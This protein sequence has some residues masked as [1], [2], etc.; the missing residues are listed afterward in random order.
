DAADGVP[1][2][3]QPGELYQ[4]TVTGWDR[5]K[6]HRTGAGERV[7]L[8]ITE[9]A[10]CEA[11]FVDP[12][13][14]TNFWGW[15]SEIT[16]TLDGN[17]RA[18]AWVW[19]EGPGVCTLSATGGSDGE[20]LEGSPKVLRW[21]GALVNRDV[22]NT[23]FTVSQAPVPADGQSTGTVTVQL[24]DAENQPVF[25]A[26]G[27]LSAAGP[28]GGGVTVGAFTHAGG[29]VYTATFT[30]TQLGWRPITVTAGGQPLTAKDGGGDSAYF[31]APAA[32]EVPSSAQSSAWITSSGGAAA[33]RGNPALADRPE[34]WDYVTVAVILLDESGEAIT[35]PNPPLSV[36]HAAADPFGGE[37]LD[38]SDQG[39][40][41]CRDTL[42][43]DGQCPDGVFTL[44]VYSV[45][46]GIRRLQVVYGAGT[47]NQ[48]TLVNDD[49]PPST[50]LYA[51]YYA[52]LSEADSTV[53]VSPSE[54]PD[55]PDAK[56]PAL[57]T[58]TPRAVGEAYTITVTLWDAGRNNRVGGVSLDL[59]LDGEN[60]GAVFAS[61]APYALL[62]ADSNGRAVIRATSL[63]PGVCELDAGAIGG[64]P[65]T[66]V[67][68]DG[69][70]DPDSP[71]TWFSVSPGAV[72][73][74]GQDEGQIE[75]QLYGVNGRPV[76]EAVSLIQA[77]PAEG[78]GITVGAFAHLGGGRYTAAFTGTVVGS[79]AI[80]LK[81]GDVPISVQPGVLGNNLAHVVAADG[82]PPAA[83]RSDAKVTN[84]P[85]ELANHGTTGSTVAE[86]GRQTITAT[87]KGEDGEP[88]TNAA[89][90]LVAEAGYGDPVDGIGLYFGNQ[91]VFAC[92]AAPVD[93]E[94]E[95][96]V[97]TLDV[98]S[99]K[100]GERQLT[101][102]YL[103]GTP[104]AVAL[105]NGDHKASKVLRTIFATPPISRVD[106]TVVV[107]PS[108]PQDNPDDPF[109]EPDGVPVPLELG[110]GQVYKVTV[111]AWDA[112]RNNR[113]AGQEIS[114]ALR[115]VPDS[116][117]CD[118]RFPGY[119]NYT[120]AVTSEIGQVELY[121]HQL[122]PAVGTCRLDV[123]LM[124]GDHGAL[125]GSPKRLS[126]VNTQVDREV[127]EFWV[128]PDDVAANGVDVGDIVV[129]L[130]GSQDGDSW[131]TGRQDLLKTSVKNGAGLHVTDFIEEVPGSYLA[132][133][134]GTQTGVFELSVEY[135]GQP[136]RASVST[137]G[138]PLQNL[139][140]LV[141]ATDP[142][143]APAQSM[144]WGGSYGTIQAVQK[145]AAGQ[146]TVNFPGQPF[147]VYA[148]L[149]DAAGTPLLHNAAGLR[150]EVAESDPFGDVGLYDLEGG[151]FTPTFYCGATP[152]SDCYRIGIYSALPGE[153]HINVF[154]KDQ[155]LEFALVNKDDPPSTTL[156]LTYAP[157]TANGADSTMVVSPSAPVDNPLD[158]SDPPDGVPQPIRAG[159][160]YQVVLTPWDQ[161]RL[162]R[163]V[164]EDLTVELAP[165]D[166]C[167][168]VLKKAGDPLDDPSEW[169][170]NRLY[171][172]DL[173]ANQSGQRVTYVYSEGPAV[174][175]LMAGDYWDELAGSPK[176]L[177]WVGSTADPEGENTWF[178]VSPQGVLADGLATGTVTVQLRG[179]GDVPVHDAAGYL[180]ASG[181]QAGGITLGAF[182]HAGG[183]VYTATFTGTV[184]GDQ[185]ISVSVD[186]KALAVRDPGNDS[187]HMV[188]SVG[189]GGPSPQE[190]SVG[191]YA[192][193]TP[194]ANRGNPA[195]AQRPEEWGSYR[196]TAALVD[197]EGDPVTDPNPPLSVTAA[198]GDPSGG[199][200]LDYSNGGV[201]TCAQALDGDGQCAGGRF[202]VDVYSVKAG[203][204]QLEVVY[205]AGTAEEFKLLSDPS[206]PSTVLR[207]LFEVFVSEEDSTVAITPSDPQDDPDAA[208][209]ATGTPLPVAVGEPYTVTVTLWDAG[210]NNLITAENWVEL[211]LEGED[212]RAFFPNNEDYLDLSVRGGRASTQVISQVIGE[213]ELVS[214]V[215][216]PSRT[217]IWGDGAVDTASDKTWFD[218]SP[219]PVVVGGQDQGGIEVQLYGVNGAPMVQAAGR[220]T[221]SPL[222]QD[223]GLT[224]SAFTHLG[225]G[226]YTAA[227]SGAKA[228]SFQIAVTLGDVPLSVQAGIGND[229]ARLVQAGGPP[230][231]AAQS[232]A[233]ITNNP[234]QAANRGAP[235]S[236]VAEWGRQT[237]TVTL[238]DADGAPL[239]AA[240]GDL[241]AAAGP[242]DPLDGIGLYFG[243]QNLFVCAQAPEAG[244]CAAGVY[245]LDVYSSK[246][247]ERQLTVT[248]LPGTPQAIVLVNGDLDTSRVLRTVFTTP[249]MSLADS[250]VVVTPSTPQDN[251]DDPLDEPDGVPTPVGLGQANPFR[252]T[253]TTWDAG[254]NNRVGGQRVMLSLDYY[255]A[256]GTCLAG[257]VG[258]PGRQFSVET[259]A[260]GR[261]EAYV[262]LPTTSE[263]NACYLTA[264]AQDGL[265][266]DNGQLGGSP[267]LLRWLE[268]EVNWDPDHTFFWVDQN[269]VAADGADV[270]MVHVELTGGSNGF[271]V[272]GGK[273][274]KLALEAPDGSGIRS[275]G[276]VQTYPG[277]YEGYFAGTTAGDYELS[278]TYDG[279]ALSP[280]DQD[281]AAATAHFVAPSE[282]PPVPLHSL[283]WT[284]QTSARVSQEPAP[285]ERTEFLQSEPYLV[286]VQLA[287][288][289]AAS[290][291]RN[292]GGLTWKA[293]DT[294]PFQGEG[295]FDLQGG[296]FEAGLPCPGAGPGPG[297]SCYAIEIHSAIPGERHITVSYGD[298]RVE[299]FLL[300]DKNNIP[301]TTLK[302]TY[303]LPWASLEDSTLVVSPSAPVDNPLDPAD[304]ADG[305]ATPVPAGDFYDVVLT[306]WDRDRVN[307]AEFDEVDLEVQGPDCAAV[308]QD[309]AFPDDPSRWT[310]DS[311]GADELTANADGQL[312]TR[313][314]S[315]RPGV[316]GL[317]AGD[318]STDLAGS[319]KVLRWV[320][321]VAD[322]TH[323]NTWF[324]VSPEDV[325]ADGVDAGVVTVQLRDAAGLPVHDAAEFVTAAG[326]VGSGVAVGAFTHVGGG[327]Y[328]A[329]FTGAQIG[330]F[331]LTA[332]VDGSA[333]TLWASGQG[334]AHLVAAGEPGG[335]SPSKSSAA[336]TAE[337]AEANRGDPD[338]AEEPELWGFQTI[339]VALK[340]SAGE[341]VT[342]AA[343]PLSVAAA[344][345]DPL[346]G[347]GLDYS[348][349]GA[350][351]CAEALV[352]GECPAGVFKVDVYS[353]KVGV[354]QLEV[355]Y[356]AGTPDAFTLV[357]EANAPSTV[358]A[359][360]FVATEPSPEYSTLTV[361][362]SVP[363][364]DPD[365]P[366]DEPDGVP[367][368]LSVGES[369]TVTITLWDAGRN[370]RVPYDDVFMVDLVGTDG[371]C[372]ARFPDGHGG[373]VDAYDKDQNG[374]IVLQVTSRE[375]GDCRIVSSVTPDRD[376]YLVW[377]AAPVDPASARTWFSVSAGPVVADG[378]DE[379]QIEVQLYGTDGLPV[380]AAAG[381]I[382]V[383]VPAGSGVSADGFTDQGGGRYTTAFTGTVPGLYALTV[384]A[385][386]KALSTHAG[387]GN[388]KAYLV[389]PGEPPPAGSGSKA[390]VSDRENQLANHDRPNSTAAEWGRQTI[391]AT[392]KGADG[393]PLTQGVLGL[394]AAAAPGDPVD[395]I[396]L[397][398]GN[399]GK[400]ACATALVDGECAAGVYTLDVYSSKAGERQLVVTYLAGTPDQVTLV[401]GDHP[402]S[403]VL[404]ARFDAPPASRADSI[405]E[406]EPIGPDGLPAALINGAGQAY[407]VTVIAWDEGRNNL[408]P[409]AEFELELEELRN[410][411]R[412][413]PC[414][415]TRFW[416]EDG[417]ET[418][419]VTS[420]TGRAETYVYQTPGA[421]PGKC[422]LTAMFMSPTGYGDGP[423]ADS[424]RVLTWES[425]P[426]D[427]RWSSFSV[428]TEPVLADG[429]DLG[430]IAVYLNSNDMDGWVF[431]QADRL[432]VKVPPG[433]GIEVR[434]FVEWDQG[435]YLARFTGT[436]EGLW[437]LEVTYDGHPVA[438]EEDY[439]T[440]RLYD[441][442]NMV[443]AGAAAVPSAA[444]SEA[445]VDDTG[446]L[447][448]MARPT[449]DVAGWGH[450]MFGWNDTY[451]H[452]VM[453]HLVD[454]EGHPVPNAAGALSWAPAPDDPFGG[455]GLADSRGGV[456]E[457]GG[458]D[459][460]VN[461][462]AEGYYWV[463]IGSALAGERL[464][465]VS[466]GNGSISFE[467]ANRDNPPSTELS[468]EFDVP[469]IS[470]S[471]STLV[472][473][474]SAPQ[475]NPDD[476]QDEP[477][478]V[479]T[480]INAGQSYQVTVTG[481]S[482]N[483]EY[484]SGRL[485]RYSEV[486]AIFEL[487]RSDSCDAYMVDPDDPSYHSSGVELPLDA[488]GRVTTTVYSD[489]PGVCQLR[490]QIYGAGDVGGS[491]KTLRWV[492][493][494]A[495]LSH[496]NTW[497]TVSE[498]D[499]VANGADA[500]TVTV[501]LRDADNEPVTDAAG[502]L[503]ASAAVGSGVAVGGFT[504]LGGGVYT[505][506]FTGTV[507]GTH[508]I[509]ATADGQDLALW[510]SG[511]GDA[512][513]VAPAAPGEADS[514]QSWAAITDEYEAEANRGDPELADQPEW[515]GFQT[516][517]VT[518]KDA[519]GAPIT[520]AAP[521]LSVAAAASD[522]FAGAGLDYSN[523][524]AFVCAEALAGGECAAGVYTL[525]V[526]SVKAG[527]RQLEVTYSAGGPDTFKL[528]NAAKPPSP[529][530]PATFA[531]WG[532][533]DEYSTMVVSP[534][535]PVDDPDDPA[536]DDDGVPDPIFAGQWYTVT[537]TFWDQ[538]RNNRVPY[539]PATE[540]RVTDYGEAECH[541]ILPNG[542]QG[543]IFLADGTG[544]AVTKFYSD[545]PGQCLLESNFRSVVLTWVE[546]PVDVASP[547]TWFTVSP[548]AVLADGQ[549]E[550][551][552]E[553]QL[554]GVDG[555]AITG[556]ASQLEVSRPDNSG[557]AVSGFTHT[558]AGRYTATFTGTAEGVFPLAVTA[559]G[560]A[561]AV[562]AVIGNDKAYLVSADGPPPAG[563]RSF[564]VVT[565]RPDEPANHDA[566]SSTQ[567]EWGRQTITATLKNA[568][569]QAI[570]QGALGLKAAAGTGDPLDGIGLYYGNGGNFACAAAPVGG[571]C[572]AGV[573][574]LD[575]YSSKA[576]ER[577]LTVTYRPGTADEL[578]LVNGGRGVS[579][580]LRA[581]FATPPFSPEYSTLMI[582]PSVP[583]DNP[584]DPLDNPD[585][586]PTTLPYGR[587]GRYHLTV[588]TWDEGRNNRV[589]GVPL[590]LIVWGPDCEAKFDSHVYEIYL[591]TSAIGRAETDVY[592][593]NPT[594]GEC[595]LEA[596]VRNEAG[597]PASAVG[598]QIGGSPKTLTW[599][600]PEADPD[601][602]SFRVPP[603]EVVANGTD[604][605]EI[606]VTLNGGPAD[607]SVEVPGQA[608]R[609]SAKAPDGS[610]ITIGNFVED[611]YGYVAWFTGTKA[612]TY[613]IEVTYDGQPLPALN[614]NNVVLDKAV[615]VSVASPR[616]AVAQSFTWVNGPWRVAATNP[617]VPGRLF[618]GDYQQVM[619]RLV[620]ADG[621]GVKYAQGGLS[622][623]AAASD[624]LG[625]EGLFDLS[626]G[627]FGCANTGIFGETCERGYYQIALYS[628]KPGDR[629]IT[630]SYKDETIEFDVV[631]RDDQP[632]TVLTVP[633]GLPDLSQLDSTMVVSPSVPVDDPNDPLDE[634]DGV[635]VPLKVGETY[636]VTVTA[637]AEGRA[638][639]A[640][641]AH[642]VWLE[643]VDTGTCDAGFGDPSLPEEEQDWTSLGWNWQDDDIS[644]GVAYIRGNGAG[645][646]ILR[647][648][649][650]PLGGSPKTLRWVG[651][652]T[653]AGQA[654][655]WYTVSAEPVQANG[656][657]TGTITVQL[658]DADNAP[659]LDAAGF[660]D[661]SAPV[662]S[663]VTV[664]GFTHAGGGVYT[665]PYTGVYAG[666]YPVAVSVD[667]EE[668]PLMDGGRSTTNLVDTPAPALDLSRSSLE[669]LTDGD[670]QV[671]G[672]GYSPEFAFR[673]TLRDQNG[674]P[675]TEPETVVFS[676]KEEGASVW[677]VGQSVP[678]SAG[679][680][681]WGSFAV[682]VPGSY[683]VKAEVAGAQVGSALAVEF[684]AAA[685]DP[686]ESVFECVSCDGPVLVG[687]SHT[688]RLSLRDQFGGPW[689]QVWRQGRSLEYSYRLVGESGWTPGH[690]GGAYLDVAEW[691]AFTVAAHGSYEVRVELD[692]VQLGQTVVVVFEPAPRAP[693]V[694][695]SWLVQPAADDRAAANGVST[696]VVG[697]VVRDAAGEPFEGAVVSFLIPEWTSAGLSQG[698][699]VVEAV[700]DG[701]G[702]ASVELVSPFM[703]VLWDPLKVS[704]TVDGAAFERL[705][706]AGD[707]DVGA[708][709]GLPAVVALNF[710]PRRVASG[711]GL[712]ELVSPEDPAPADGVSQLTIK[713]LLTDQDG[714]PFAAGDGFV[715]FASVGE[716]MELGGPGA[717]SVDVPVGAS[718]VA[719]LAVASPA[720]GVFEFTASA[721]ATVYGA[722][723]YSYSSQCDIAQ[724][725]PAVAEFQNEPA[726]LDVSRSSFEWLTEGGVPVVG[727]PHGFGVSLVDQY[728]EAWT[729]PEQVVFSYRASSGTAWTVGA[730]LTTVNGAAEWGSFTVSAPGSYE[731]KAEVAGSQVGSAVTVEFAAPGL[732]L[733]AIRAS[734]THSTGSVDP[735]GAVHW[736]YVTVT[737][738]L[739]GFVGG[740]NVSFELT[741]P[742]SAFLIDRHSGSP[743]TSPA[744]IPSSGL[745]S[746]V[747]DVQATEDT[748][749]H[750]VVSIGSEV[751]GEVDFSFVTPTQPPVL[752]LSQSSFDWLTQG[753][754]PVVGSP[755]RF[756]VSLSD[757]YGDPWA[758][759][760]WIVFSYRADGATPWTLG[761]TVL[762][763]VDGTAEWGSFAVASPGFY[764]V[765]AEYGWVGGAVIGQPVTVEFGV[766]G[767]DLD[768]VRAS[769]AHSAGSV[770][771]AG[772][773]HW[774]SVVVSDVL[775]G[776]VEGRDVSVVLSGA[777][778]AFLVDRVG[779]SVLANPAVIASSGLGAA[780][781]G[782][783]AT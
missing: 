423:I 122:T 288:A 522:P 593:R 511:Q 271:A 681:E 351:A 260:T 444:A 157:A 91:G 662:S 320:G 446:D 491:P 490:V 583:E 437:Q 132:H 725:S 60:C 467:L 138:G 345:S 602:S 25:D 746:A 439:Y 273:A 685:L 500:G 691:G 118:A 191:I 697:A 239:T 465:T 134:Y 768:A 411:D 329:P 400:F 702:Y 574:T 350:F 112:G 93:G 496:V 243:N 225:G 145:P 425:A 135:D 328:T 29:G 78:S 663:G 290:L 628:S 21:L 212:C 87:L 277:R 535:T 190:S 742:G 701:S 10:E 229:L 683:E 587:D 657:D 144:F 606:R 751:V 218:V 687:S 401:N 601:R 732:D 705:R 377:E 22:A 9:S 548:G 434:D 495:D 59:G 483:R 37:G 675:W 83:D 450:S 430:T 445:W 257:F 760:E 211:K 542:R 108:N 149:K 160:V 613:A 379:G 358:L 85:N 449:P 378:Q 497:Y 714:V 474:P 77:T 758:S 299:A 424:P 737:D 703:S 469:E 349:G 197:A 599:A 510:A 766:P 735:A 429:Q 194:E 527:V 729:S 552:I 580:V 753:E 641:L 600:Y 317:T 61:G 201:F 339:T 639:R 187:A 531:V 198:A 625:G 48:F 738:M 524:G 665:A 545:Q 384:T 114:L 781:V 18:T 294:D 499:V 674:E 241:V 367:T 417:N 265:T 153:R 394:A 45:K 721:N 356:G 616:P 672:E 164:F 319:P 501:Q 537:L 488:S 433:S 505:A 655:T 686:A 205:G 627:F 582:T 238:K 515:W 727:S 643:L 666:S 508:A 530:L 415:D 1:V 325:V 34:D 43:A 237:I 512:R 609:L 383:G 252:I 148:Q 357:N 331:A 432:A 36:T 710:D 526:Y 133:F 585:G 708:S 468:L 390:V 53:V 240:A 142:T 333:L 403:S 305:V 84:R 755:H 49:L 386:G 373:R 99:S 594:A 779:G 321:S 170:E 6:A 151:F 648:E 171:L 743:L 734:F 405:L 436:V 632:N 266:E 42:D 223:S 58:P 314:Y 184:V 392:L 407:K 88:L 222:D 20:E 460:S 182:R 694:A 121:V 608:A 95:N 630:I 503:A 227:F 769:F 626:D 661:G 242:G 327:V 567:A 642:G 676:Y 62:A 475:D 246:A 292:A 435:E 654:D 326:P 253:V 300:M 700:T 40:F 668:L 724:G 598:Q 14:P 684:V 322:P 723:G 33:N 72:V 8:E 538:G 324:A 338:L 354:R 502:L 586:V 69:A 217:L 771:P 189:G 745:G 498:Q 235:Q 765:K 688:L 388:D 762:T 579:K 461:S 372:A 620:D 451:T 307:R 485:E 220:L 419:L 92:A 343:P 213:C 79:H 534:S 519:A 660:I 318:Y 41:T 716:A 23:W 722:G 573:Y 592:V 739:G 167:D 736:A 635:P 113:V 438:A 207:A 308:F 477:D 71:K 82:P 612:G 402:A 152:E 447:S 254:R 282:P 382:V 532:E 656:V 692:G 638:Q 562:Q 730:T 146:S 89:A 110:N 770:D 262:Y 268:P 168:A 421:A 120:Y 591:D 233:V 204:R 650:D 263:L 270:G 158:P 283:M 610:G 336:V 81:A 30:G 248:Y 604:V 376:V 750:L 717:Y 50:V 773:G 193:R 371:D 76:T 673:A 699:V 754:V 162:G 462:C 487:V 347:A 622:W 517:T 209:P 275:L 670:V 404:R 556:A 555:R 150:W 412:S 513:L 289:D 539:S 12:A 617:P 396:G 249:P 255:S 605:G 576:G 117:Y 202:T 175:T 178:T 330:V 595:K 680:A 103:P 774:A 315:A 711:P 251:A 693:S 302:L 588:T 55:D 236:T 244:L 140:H 199:A 521:P 557:L 109:D 200:G 287:G 335:V 706:V 528:V 690:S 422:L 554:F 671:I 123:V 272:L 301:S 374:R 733:D 261:A 337:E 553:V 452:R 611:E 776:L 471:D 481:W 381:D 744:Q 506:P 276:F 11:H 245:T 707:P 165:G 154:Y 46:A 216:E 395:G 54:P 278:V 66:L 772:A 476:P 361:S 543:E 219:A 44:D 391:T 284:D 208:A 428:G 370:N 15:D 494:G 280:E 195:L 264:T 640:G 105:V 546:A 352:G 368:T 561:I 161:N 569:G 763:G 309:P 97:Y 172:G 100:A 363:E 131:V 16:P 480:A 456:F 303:D 679:V 353:V 279:Q 298:E 757:Q 704:A 658:R 247:G 718:G 719:E 169:A 564:A 256:Y 484:R 221:A 457:C 533:S 578:T 177:R 5:G 651:S 127:S 478:G 281:P 399:S 493:S 341:P 340:D 346:A 90:G 529:V 514:A 749:A 250:T 416:L 646:C 597:V 590:D 104:D 441:T 141:A 98:Y 38:Y 334:D 420:A 637:W 669:K 35:D 188:A 764:Q 427:L 479:P 226:Q 783:R 712:S 409:D 523:G 4:V 107:T 68:T 128:Q 682:T 782:V 192:D 653:D 47:A 413:G 678:A 752:D 126:W 67:W 86:W 323:A 3:L 26:A 748:T 286:E 713:A 756:R 443:A 780:A 659:A 228:G 398:F 125:G 369:Y 94:C 525:D 695:E 448:P 285:G 482:A 365:D 206:A 464:I 410:A 615:L 547:K 644:Q 185:L 31:A 295:L 558:G 311:V 664:G 28:V 667:G 759:P 726:R 75:V 560:Q 645:T 180:S 634:P 181:P 111:T 274:D 57:G 291:G 73:A 406:I 231:G 364:D 473:S 549:D 385:Q 516:I 316:C 397:Y 63:T 116:P 313:V 258:G 70:I 13:D 728:G 106:S 652:G 65:K 647:S 607:W 568:D 761:E 551:Q 677:T 623:A 618:E 559:D 7:S 486:K 603:N 544:Q 173:E 115:S 366:A 596:Y 778:S 147:T 230:V 454:S 80:T 186:G 359:A 636:V 414:D 775:G 380:T 731:V 720:A 470:D 102:T 375:A 489:A 332:Q 344:A 459:L 581:V 156:V 362:P 312:T 393:A 453:V 183:G 174:C 629:K 214:S 166:A 163:A 649:Y 689:L 2:P 741:S 355:T 504:H 101:V 458:W 129:T 296:V 767:L 577:H 589:G 19:S 39:E 431:G 304:A 232:S 203:V 619:V 56:A 777:G 179:E 408:V 387:A 455:Q 584:D 27:S 136:L 550:G 74:D 52:E 24:R 507:A 709:N 509:T 259:S 440:H 540:V 575:V 696:Q 472:V 563:D 210:R 492:G 342:D 633:Y 310:A 130:M 418:W 155:Q 698:P 348:N 306:G 572:V 466:Y 747:V 536:D 159:E 571:E 389:A 360:E 293:A 64:E 139:A 463:L 614:E 32:P 267:K 269:D 565:Q 124:D 621:N 518:L 297:G 426:V 442:A 119:S 17:G 196:I 137:L 715:R 520:D 234:D 224:I 96:G 51:R 541:A 624:P 566:P 143:P 631:A 215:G 176:V 740:Q 570:T